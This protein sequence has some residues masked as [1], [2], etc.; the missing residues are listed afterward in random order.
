M[1]ADT[2]QLLSSASAQLVES[3]LTAQLLLDSFDS[4]VRLEA[5][6]RAAPRTASAVR[7]RHESELRALQLREATYLT[8]PA[9]A[10]A[11]AKWQVRFLTLFY[12]FFFL[13]YFRRSE[14]INSYQFISISIYLDSFQSIH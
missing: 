10:D 12:I 11:F 6:G 1:S 14:V 7:E 4:A 5:S 13:H 8:E 2:A 9:P 3:R